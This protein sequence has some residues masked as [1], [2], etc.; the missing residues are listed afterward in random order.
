ML[1]LKLWL[2]W[3]ISAT[4]ISGLD[5]GQVLHKVHEGHLQCPCGAPLH[6]RGYQQAGK[7]LQEAPPPGTQFNCSIS[8]FN[9]VFN[10]DLLVQAWLFTVTMFRVTRCW[11]WQFLKFADQ[12]FTNKKC[13]FAVTIAYSDTFSVS[14]GYHCKWLIGNSVWSSI[15]QVNLAPAVPRQRVQRH[16]L[17]LP[18]QP[19]RVVGQRGGLSVRAAEC[20]RWIRG[21]GAQYIQCTHV[22]YS[23]KAEKLF[24][25][26][27]TKLKP[28]MLGGW[29]H[30]VCVTSCVCCTAASAFCFAAI[31]LGGGNRNRK[32]SSH[33]GNTSISKLDILGVLKCIGLH[34]RTNRSRT[35]R[36]SPLS[37]CLAP[38]S[39]HTSFA[40][41]GNI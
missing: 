32:W 26:H 9:L 29:L 33:Y 21:T 24:S 27:L 25:R 37:S 16:R 28:K 2:D 1:I 15:E 11:Q 39:L 19:Q 38:S 13:L 34:H 20:H 17:R 8:V 41:S 36:C 30:F 10:C 40:S 23:T 5:V 22:K 35:R 14:R 12:W 4:L 3:L 6:L 7:D 31:G 18:L